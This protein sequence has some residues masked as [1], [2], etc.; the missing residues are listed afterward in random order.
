MAK[1]IP[2]NRFKEHLAVKFG[3][4]L[5][6]VYSK[7]FREYYSPLGKVVDRFNPSHIEP[8]NGYQLNE[9][10]VRL[11]GVEFG[12]RGNYHIIRSFDSI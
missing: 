9:S 1:A 5:R 8:T 4:Y 2:T 7:G 3:N 12:R 11:K 10:N 6:E